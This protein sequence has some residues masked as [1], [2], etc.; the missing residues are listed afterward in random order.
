MFTPLTEEETKAR[1]QA[2]KIEEMANQTRG[3]LED[4]HSQQP[5]PSQEA[6]GDVKEVSSSIISQVVNDAAKEVR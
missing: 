3:K 6:H 2:A 1:L 4:K 5:T